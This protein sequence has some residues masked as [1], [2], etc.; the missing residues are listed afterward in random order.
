[1]SLLLQALQKAAKNRKGDEGER[2]SVGSDNDADLTLEPL[3][4]PQ[5]GDPESA[6]TEAPPVTAKLA[7]SSAAQPLELLRSENHVRIAAQIPVELV[8][9]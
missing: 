5:L 4:E 3:A 7:A 1:M 6:P 8:L 9:G 2:A